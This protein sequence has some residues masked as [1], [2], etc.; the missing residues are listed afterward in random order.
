MQADSTQNSKLALIAKVTAE[1][2]Q[3]RPG[4]QT[5]EFYLVALVVAALVLLSSLGQI[6]ST[7]ADAVAGLIALG[8]AWLRGNR[9]N[10]R[11]ESLLNLIDTLKGSDLPAPATAVPVAVPQ[12]AAAPAP[13]APVC[14]HGTADFSPSLGSQLSQSG[15]AC[16]PLLCALSLFVA[17]LLLLTGCASTEVREN[18]QRVF[19]TH[20]D[21]QS[22]ELTTKNTH[23]VMTGVSHSQP[24]LAGGQAFKMGADSVGTTVVSGILSGG[25]PWA[26][27]T[28]A[29]AQI[30]PQI[31][32]PAAPVV[33]QSKH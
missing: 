6:P 2:T 16:L 12:P 21:A 23:L 19:H 18:G 30:I 29:G 3:N 20:A 26:K 17:I 9:K 22:I 33:L 25:L 1:I 13:A 32:A 14:T 4:W 28:A 7:A 24:T 5:T 27:A 11:E 10:S 15:S 8:F 31:L